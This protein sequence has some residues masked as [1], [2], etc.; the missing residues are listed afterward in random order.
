MIIE[1]ACT[2]LI[3]PH[4]TTFRRGFLS[5]GCK[6][7]ALIA[8][9]AAILVWAALLSNMYTGCRYLR[10]TSCSAL[11]NTLSIYPYNLLELRQ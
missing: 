4:R 5:D 2:I 9:A 6:R 3:I 11:R 10:P 7:L 8:T 1:R